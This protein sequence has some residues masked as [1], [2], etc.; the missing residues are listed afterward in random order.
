MLEFG[1]EL[2]KGEVI[3]VK[4]RYEDPEEINKGYEILIMKDADI[5][6]DM[7]GAIYIPDEVEMDF[8]GTWK[9]KAPYFII[10]IDG[11]KTPDPNYWFDRW[12]CIQAPTD[13]EALQ[14][15]YKRYHGWLR[16]DEKKYVK[17][18]AVLAKYQS[19]YVWIKENMK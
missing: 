9:L 4:E 5:E 2:V 14:E 1:H 18:H 3:K 10:G 13:K 6:V 19:A 11:R 15:Y 16:E 7:G 8:V 17:V 12:E